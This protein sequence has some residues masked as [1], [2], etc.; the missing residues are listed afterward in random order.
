[1]M[2]MWKNVL[3]QC[4]KSNLAEAEVTAWTAPAAISTP[5]GAANATAVAENVA[6]GATLFTATATG[7]ATYS[8]TDNAGGKGTIGSTSGIVTLATGQSIDYETASSLKFVIIATA[9]T[10]AN[11]TATITLPITDVNEAPAF[12]S[13]TNTVCIND[14]SAEAGNT[15]TD[16]AVAKTTG[17]ITVATGKTLSKATAATYAL[18]VKAVDNAATALTGS[19]TVSVTVGGCSG[20]GALTALLSLMS[21]AMIATKLL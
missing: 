19:T 10:G 13:P 6:E 16:F 3:I 15:N 14:N 2:W 18:V 7:A 1:M 4:Y 5:S 20:T 8:L 12:S 17:V 11:G 9:T 21:V